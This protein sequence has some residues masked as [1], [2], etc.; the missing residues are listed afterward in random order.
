VSGI[1]ADHA[2]GRFAFDGL[3]QRVDDK[4]PAPGSEWPSTISGELSWTCQPW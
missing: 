1:S 2:S 3:S 4:M